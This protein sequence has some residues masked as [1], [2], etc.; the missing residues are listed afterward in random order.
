MFYEE[1]KEDI[2]HKY[3]QTT[4]KFQQKIRW[5]KIFLGLIIFFMILFIIWIIHFNIKQN[6]DNYIIIQKKEIIYQK[7]KDN[8]H[9]DNHLHNMK[10]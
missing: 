4:R 1:E 5:R 10:K 8:S 7:N 2:N 3:D 9:N 6:N